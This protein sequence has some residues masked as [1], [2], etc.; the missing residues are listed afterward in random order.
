MYSHYCFCYTS[1]SFLLTGHEGSDVT[2]GSREHPFEQRQN[3]VRG[4]EPYEGESLGER[5]IASCEGYHFRDFGGFSYR[6][7][8]CHC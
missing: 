7:H 6:D 8:S 4:L 1:G 5:V 3:M 2:A